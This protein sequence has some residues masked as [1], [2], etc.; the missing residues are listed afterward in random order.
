MIYSHTANYYKGKGILGEGS[1]NGSDND[2]DETNNDIDI[3][4]SNKDLNQGLIQD[5]NQ[6][7]DENN[8]HVDPTPVP[9]Q[10][11]S[12]AFDGTSLVCLGELILKQFLTIL[13]NLSQ[14]FFSKN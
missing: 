2:S 10:D 3:G 7:N 9:R 4:S 1:D 13:T 14:A 6:S 12:Y 8:N 5:N 11:M